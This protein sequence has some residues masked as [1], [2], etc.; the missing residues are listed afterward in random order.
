MSI[1][2]YT[3]HYKKLARFRQPLWL[4][5]RGKVKKFN[6]QKW[7]ASKKTYFPNKFKFFNQNAAAYNLGKDF[8]DDKIIRFKKTY[9]Y[10][11]QD[12][13]RLQLYFGAG[14]LRYYQLKALSKTALRLGKNKTSLPA[15]MLL[16]LLDNRL[17]NVFYRLSF[18]SSLMQGKRIINCGHVKIGTSLVTNST[19]LVKRFDLI[20][21]DPAVSQLITLLYLRYN[22]PFFY[23]KRKRFCCNM[24]SRRISCFSD[25]FLANN[26]QNSFIFIQSTL[27]KIKRYRQKKILC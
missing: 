26:S 14:R 1:K 16:Y 10:I 17:Q 24:I 23:F 9:K 13:Q 8:N 21:L 11:L 3:P 19:Y 18:V 20:Q 27:E 2:R 22:F 15:S 7:E 6:R 5:K 25:G 12:K 4:E